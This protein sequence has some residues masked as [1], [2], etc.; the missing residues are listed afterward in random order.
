MTF[1]KSAAVA[2]IF[3][4][5]AGAAVA[6]ATLETSEAPAG[7]YYKAVIRVPHGCDGQAT[8][9]VRVE[10]PEGM[11][12]AKPMPKAGWTLTT[13]TGAYQ[14]TYTSHGRDV[15]EGVLA[16][17]WSEGE[18]PNDWY[19]EFVFRGKLADT[20]EAD[21]VLHFKTY[22]TCADGSVNWIDIPAE[23]QDRHDVKRP[24]PALTITEGHHHH[25]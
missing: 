24:A 20:L 9:T 18:L 10:V 22:Q 16:V 12:G 13:E 14:N 25:H 6:H 8:R 11:I 4:C 23:G 19:D 21:T 3:S 17:T 2:A 5:A 7:S 1:F 15:S